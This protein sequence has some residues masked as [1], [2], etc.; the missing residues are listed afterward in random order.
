MTAANGELADG[1]LRI[2]SGPNTGSFGF[3]QSPAFVVPGSS[4]AALADA[5]TRILDQAAG[6]WT[7]TF[8]VS[9]DQTDATQVPTIRLRTTTMDASQS[10]VL[11]IESVGDAAFS[12]SA[13]SP[14][15]YSMA[16]RAAEGNPMFQLQFDL[17]NF[18]G[19]GAEGSWIRLDRVT[20]GPLDEAFLSNS[21]VDA[22][23]D[24]ATGTQGWS[25]RTVNAPGFIAPSGSHGN[26]ALNLTSV[27]F[28]NPGETQ[29][30]WWNGPETLDAGG[31]LAEP[32]RLYWAE[33]TVSTDQTDANVVP[34]FR[35]RLNGSSFR[36][37]RL[38]QASSNF[39]GRAQAGS[40]N[41]PTAGNPRTYYVILP[42]GALS[43]E[44]LF[45]SFDLLTT[46]ADGDAAGATVSLDSIVIR[47]STLP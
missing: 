46:E 12:P 19:F 30:G 25:F 45:P 24:F 9:T 8:T 22:S 44:V 26:G 38:T 31:L 20:V 47:S 29:F 18:N 3:W 10:D 40:L 7:T 1:G 6:F 32:G 39:D 4:M 5:D 15:E 14:R 41:V 28:S 35:M 17:V 2:T 11:A 36:A 21:R 37:G 43:N 23:Y 13:T 34:S 16:W 27:P 42:V 33:F